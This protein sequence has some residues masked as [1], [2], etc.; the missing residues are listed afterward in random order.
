[1]NKCFIVLL[2][3]L[4]TFNLIACSNVHEIKAPC[5]WNSRGECGSVVPM[6]HQ[7]QI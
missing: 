7:D 6:S 5:G 4:S 2:T 1:M 3:V